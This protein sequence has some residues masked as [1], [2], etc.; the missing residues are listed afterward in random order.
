MKAKSIFDYMAT[1]PK[2]LVLCLYNDKDVAN[3][4]NYTFDYNKEINLEKY[5]RKHPQNN[6]STKYKFHCDR[7]STSNYF[8]MVAFCVHFDGL[9]YEFNDSF[10]KENNLIY[11]HSIKKK[12]RKKLMK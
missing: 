10:Y 6:H 1:L 9:I 2:Y 8:H 3:P 5:Y 12:K 4:I 7:Y 11:Y